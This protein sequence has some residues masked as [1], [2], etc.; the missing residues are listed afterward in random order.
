MSSR[1]FRPTHAALA[2][3]VAASLAA[4]LPA[5]SA[6]ASGDQ[7]YVLPRSGKF[8]VAGHGYGH[9]HG[10][11][12]YGAEGAARRGMGYR[13]IV[14]FYY[15]GTG[16]ATTTP[17]IRVRID[18]DTTPD[19][20]VLPRSGLAIRDLG[21]GKVFRLPTRASITRWRL[22][23][24]HGRTVV[25]YRTNQWHRYRTSEGTFLEGDGQFQGPGYLTLVLPGG[26]TMPV[27]GYLRAASPTPG[28]TTRDTV[29]LLGVEMYLRGVVPAEMPASW[30]QAALQAQAVA[31]RTYALY[32][33][34]HHLH[35]Y[36]QICDT[37]ACQVYRGMK[38][39]YSSS[40]RAITATRGRYLTSGGAPAFTQFSSSSG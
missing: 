5:A 3:L 34:A 2:V 36:Y 9:G 21:S 17:K 15:P 4:V 33:R 37:T 40:D 6:S 18:E 39:Q 12:Q 11:S 28:S 7:V 10:M 13:G 24:D 16:M 8:T 35:G 23:V 27:H 29:N 19:V 25:G 26:T 22:N 32:E 30:H 38:G 1:S 20:Q 31:A 14:R